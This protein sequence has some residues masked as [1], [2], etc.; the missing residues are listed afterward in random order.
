MKIC[1]FLLN[2][3]EH[4]SVIVRGHIEL[5]I[6]AVASVP[7]FLHTSTG[8]PHSS[9]LKNV[10]HQN[11]LE[12]SCYV[13]FDSYKLPCLTNQKFSTKLKKNYI[14]AL[15]EYIVIQVLHILEITRFRQ[16]KPVLNCKRLWR[17]P[18]LA[19]KNSPKLT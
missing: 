6:G 19:P 13:T 14:S 18:G 8:Q 9:L 3:S 11:V 1:R 12:L 10:E 2:V 16:L 4:I 17:K 5:W 7:S 15:V